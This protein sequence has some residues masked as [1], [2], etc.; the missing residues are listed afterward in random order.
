MDTRLL[1]TLEYSSPKVTTVQSFGRLRENHI[2]NLT[3]LTKYIR[4]SALY[5][6]SQGALHQFLQMI[7]VVRKNNFD[8]EYWDILCDES[9][10]LYNSLGFTSEL[11]PGGVLTGTV[12]PDN[13]KEVVVCVNSELPASLSNWKDW[14]PVRVK[15]HT[16]TD[17]QMRHFDIPDDSDG[18][19]VMTVDLPLLKLQYEL[20][21]IEENKKP[22]EFQENTS[23][24]LMKYPF[25]NTLPDHLDIALINRATINLSGKVP[26]ILIKPRGV[27]LLYLERD[28]DETY[29]KIVG[30]ILPRVNVLQ[31]IGQ[32]FPLV[33]SESIVDTLNSMDELVV[34][35]QLFWAKVWADI[36]KIEFITKLGSLAGVNNTEFR[37]RYTRLYRSISSDRSLDACPDKAIASII[38]DKLEDVS[39]NLL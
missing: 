14:A 12:Y 10:I 21:R 39:N 13:I 9:R 2:K 8:Y 11:S 3:S 15:H 26:E 35:K 24:F 27:T 36:T 5:A 33:S 25:T 22:S 6:T 28:T 7:D 23:S 17:L 34:T 38:K 37:T 18:Y 31:G 4:D 29:S 19:A 30:A 32:N 20:W 16:M 1:A